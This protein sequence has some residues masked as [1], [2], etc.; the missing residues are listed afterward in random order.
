MHPGQRGARLGGEEV[1][2]GVFGIVERLARTIMRRDDPRRLLARG[3]DI[4]G[5]RVEKPA[6]ILAAFGQR[7]D[8]EGTP[9]LKG[10]PLEPVAVAR[11]RILEVERRREHRHRRDRQ[12]LGIPDEIGHERS[13][14]CAPRITVVGGGI[15]ARLFATP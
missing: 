6:P 3:P 13:R 10:R 11:A 2:S 4:V 12:F 15:R 8:R 9:A 1:D 14:Q 5:E 7:E